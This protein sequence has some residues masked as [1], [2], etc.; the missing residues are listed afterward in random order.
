MIFGNEHFYDRIRGTDLYDENGNL[1][2]SSGG[3]G[4]AIQD[5]VLYHFEFVPLTLLKGDHLKGQFAFDIDNAPEYDQILAQFRFDFDLPIHP[6]VRFYPKQV[7]TANG[8]EMLLDSVTVTP[9]FTQAYVCFQPP[10]YAPWTIGRQTILQIGEQETSLY[11]SNLLFSSS[12]GGDRRA[13]SEPYWAPPT[14]NGS[15]S[16]SDFRQAAATRPLSR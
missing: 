12:T 14:K 10:S 4:P 9:T 1:I 2:N 6:E 8:L 3:W 5:P 11:N 13:G 16:R 15:V 7:I